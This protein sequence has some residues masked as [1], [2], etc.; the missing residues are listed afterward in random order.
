MGL[1]YLVTTLPSDIMMVY[2][3]PPL[4][5]RVQDAAARLVLNLGPHYHVTPALK[6]LHWLPVEHRIKYK[7]CTLMHSDSDS[8]K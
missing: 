4:N 7:L 1:M 8:D 5:Q 6:Q 2:H 3:A